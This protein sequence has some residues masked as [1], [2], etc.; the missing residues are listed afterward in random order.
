[1]QTKTQFYCVEWASIA[2]YSERVREYNLQ[3]NPTHT[4]TV[5]GHQERANGTSVAMKRA[6][7]R[8]EKIEKKCLRARKDTLIKVIIFGSDF[9][10]M[11]RIRWK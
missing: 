2:I 3:C 4:H 9:K 5:T 11:E 10:R 6:R 8:E 1:M 7:D